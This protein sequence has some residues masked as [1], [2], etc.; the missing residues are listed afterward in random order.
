MRCDVAYATSESSHVADPMKP[1]T[2]ELLYYL[3]WTGDS[4]M[5]PTWHNLGE[6][7]D[8]WAW[9]NGLSRRLAVLARERLIERHP[10]PNLD[11]VVR[12][13]QAGKQR[14]LGGRDPMQQWSRPWDGRWRF[15]MFDVPVDLGSL[16]QQLLRVLRSR[17]FGYLQRSIWV[18]PDPTNDV[19][20]MLRQTQ[21]QAD[22]FLVIEGQPAAGE[23][24]AEIVDGAWDFERINQGYERYLALV[25]IPPTARSR[26]IE[27]A[28]R[29]DAAWKSA[30]RRDPLLP[31][32]LNP[33]GYRGR[34][35]FLRRKE[36]LA[37]LRH[38]ASQPS[39]R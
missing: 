16:R 13:S 31:L 5:R 34:E 30:V 7:F 8:D 36:I 6:S 32:S 27:W 37:H 2:E 38:T 9:R 10:E 4:L 3:L 39:V 18:T 17:H 15:V 11:R 20:G 14:A 25:T 28:R 33:P 21:V 12:L 19:R 35:A 26:W 23:S 22:A 29:E 1:Q 24:D